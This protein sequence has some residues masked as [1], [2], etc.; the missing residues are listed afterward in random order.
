[1]RRGVFIG[2][3]FLLPAVVSAGNG[4]S[5]TFSVALNLKAFLSSH[6]KDQSVKSF[7]LL[8]SKL[9]R[10][11][12][13][14]DRDFVRLI[15]SKTHQRL[16][17]N[18]AAYASLEETFEK[19]SYN[20]LTGTIIFS[21]ILNHYEI[22]HQVI[23]TNYHIFILAET[24]EGQILLEATD[25]VNGFITSSTDIEARIR[26]YRQNELETQK[27]DKAYYKFKFE[28][29]NRVSMEELRGLAF[30]NKAV[31]SFNHQ[32]YEAAVQNLVKANELYS[33]HR[34]EEFAQIL[35]LS[36]QQSEL[37]IKTKENCM[38]AILSLQ[39]KLLPV[40]LASN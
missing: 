16:L 4:T 40:I 19:G 38:T 15:F 17:K 3:F 8:L 37:D 14:R 9:D 21:L 39:Q 35:L 13:K 20:C 33:S 31:D 18:Y 24:A 6:N 30:Y 2:L 34:I 36:L 25:P 11:R 22:S 12:G 7:E 26:L 29:Y 32:Q 27:N 28:L 10:K 1:M 5:S 23:E